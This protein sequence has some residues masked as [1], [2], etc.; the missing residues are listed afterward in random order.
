MAHLLFGSKGRTCI[1]IY[2]QNEAVAYALIQAQETNRAES[3]EERYGPGIIKFF[4]SFNSLIF[5][6]SY[7]QTSTDPSS[8][9]ALFLKKS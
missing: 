1:P 4:L 8:I 9:G 3:V 7:S 6:K 5:L 2:K